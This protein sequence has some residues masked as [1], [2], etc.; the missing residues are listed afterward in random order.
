MWDRSY[1]ELVEYAN[2]VGNC[3]VPVNYAANP[4]LGAWVF[5]Q[6]IAHKKGKLSGDHAQKLLEIGFDLGGK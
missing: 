1:Q 5:A 4:S 2:K 3:K 6:K